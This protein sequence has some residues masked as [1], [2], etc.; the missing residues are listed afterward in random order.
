MTSRPVTERDFGA[1]G[2]LMPDQPGAGRLRRALRAVPATADDREWAHSCR[3]DPHLAPVVDI[4]LRRV[5]AVAARHRCGNTFHSSGWKA[6]RAEAGRHRPTA[7]GAISAERSADVLHPRRIGST[8]GKAALKPLVAKCP[9]RTRGERP[10]RWA[11]CRCACSHGVM[12]RRSFDGRC[13]RRSVR[14]R[15]GRF[16]AG[17]ARM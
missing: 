14:V 2:Y 1:S 12:F 5:G 15:C 11:E 7:A 3:R 6:G 9:V 10:S 13:R 4:G 8:I 16:P 17:A